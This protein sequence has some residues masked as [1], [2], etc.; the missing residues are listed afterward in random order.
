VI[1]AREVFVTK[2]ATRPRQ[3]PAPGEKISFHRGTERELAL[4]DTTDVEVAPL[5]ELRERIA[6]PAV[7]WVLGMID[8]TVASYSWLDPGESFDYPF[9]PGCSF[10]LGPGCVYGFDA[11]TSKARRGEGLRRR[12][13]LEETQIGAELG[14]QWEIGIFVKHHIA[15]VTRSVARVGIEIVPLWRVWLK[16]AGRLGAENLLPGD[17]CVTPLFEPA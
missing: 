6:D 14:Y 4:L 15:E 1:F 7:W 13:F 11:W 2:F 16:G 17:T 3:P 9:L 10:R 5:A 12:V 8:G